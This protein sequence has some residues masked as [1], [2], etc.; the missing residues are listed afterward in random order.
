MI[1]SVTQLPM[2]LA[3]IILWGFNNTLFIAIFFILFGLGSGMLQPMINSLLAE[4]YGTKWLGEIKSLAMPLN[5]ISS[6]FSPILMGFMIDAGA[7]LGHLM[8]LL[9]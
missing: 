5:V 2:L 8:F 6:A 1:A 9:V 4:R 7:N 3:C